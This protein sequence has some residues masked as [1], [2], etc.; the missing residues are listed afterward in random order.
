MTIGLVADNHYDTFPAGEKAPWEPLPH[1]FKGQIQRTT[2]TNKRRYDIARDKMDEAI[3]VFN[4]IPEMTMV[5][6]LGDLVNNDM[7]WNLRPI[8]DSFNRARAPHYSLLG[9]HDLR[10]HNDRFGKHNATQMEWVKQKLGLT[11]WH[12]SL[13]YPPF[14]IVMIDSMV[15]EPESLDQKKKAAHM[16]WLE[17]QINDAKRN[18]KV[19]ILFAHIPIGFQTNVMGNILRSYENIALAFFGHDH[20]GGYMVQGKTHCVTLHGQIETLVNA[21][22]VVEVYVDR[23]EMT[24]F[25]RVPTRVMP[26]SEEVRSI[27]SNYSGPGQHDLHV[28]GNQPSPPEVLWAN[29]VLQ[30]PPPLMLNIPGYQKPRLP[31]TDPNSGDTIFL[32]EVYAYWPRRVRTPTPEEPVD[33]TSA[34]KGKETWLTSAPENRSGGIR[35]GPSEDNGTVAIEPHIEPLMPLPTAQERQAHASARVRPQSVHVSELP[36]ESSRM[37]FAWVLLLPAAL[38]FCMAVWVYR[39]GGIRFRSSGRY[40]C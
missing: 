38:T 24:G 21:F 14:K 11:E 28:Q 18:R 10:A 34:I 3:E 9:N 26:F 37:G 40:S 16:A 6:N 20:K 32:K 39:R 36:S 25:G 23:A 5:V 19:V 33:L 13:D 12:Y 22:A 2:N 8:L 27:L 15:M 1:W 7:M 30:K 17:Q 31:P 35:A 29:E 4:M